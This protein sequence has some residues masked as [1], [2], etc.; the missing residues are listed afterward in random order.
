[1]S[2]DKPNPQYPE[3]GIA[4]VSVRAWF[5]ERNLLGKE[6]AK[7]MRKYIR[8]Q[9]AVLRKYKVKYKP[10]YV[11]AGCP[12]C[13]N[14]FKKEF[15]IVCGG[16]LTDMELANRGLP[17]VHFD[18][19]SGTLIKSAAQVAYENDLL[20]TPNYPDGAARRQWNQL[21]DVTKWSWERNPTPRITMEIQSKTD[22]IVNHC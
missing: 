8:E 16:C 13:G 19:K 2:N 20:I 11:I 21:D 5:R 10:Q 1:M 6:A 17:A 15:F 18:I 7:D 4:Y 12:R 3:F 22:S 14:Q 9:L